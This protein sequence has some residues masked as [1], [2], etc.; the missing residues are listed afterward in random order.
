MWGEVL[1]IVAS[2]GFVISS[3]LYYLTDI[4]APVMEQFAIIFAV[5]WISEVSFAIFFLS[6]LMYY[7]AWRNGIN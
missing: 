3:G 1:N 7:S 2:I 6:S 5:Y 4:Q